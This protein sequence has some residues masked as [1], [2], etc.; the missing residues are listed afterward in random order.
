MKRV[1]FSRVRQLLRVIPSEA[2]DLTSYAKRCSRDPSLAL[3]MTTFFCWV[4]CL[5]FVVTFAGS[6]RATTDDELRAVRFD[7]N[8]DQRIPLDT[9][10]RDE[11]GRVVTLAD[12]FG[13]DKKPVVLVPGYFGCPMLCGAISNG[14]IESLQELRFDIGKDFTVLHLSIDPREGPAEAAAKKQTYLT[15]YGRHG[16]DAG[17][18]FLT[19]SEEATRRIADEIGFHYFYD[20]ATKQYAH[21]SGIVILTPEGKIARYFF[22]V[23]F[24]PKQLR[25]ALVEASQNKIGS[26]ID[27]LMLLCFHY[28]PL[29]GKYSFAILNVLRGCGAATVLAMAGFIAVSIK[30]NR[31][32]VNGAN[33]TATA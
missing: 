19:G 9:A 23:N 25:L 24:E 8:L 26:P 18:H 20:A 27:Q 33:G 30:R 28:N 4:V 1:K 16:A 17:W 3:R 14:L 7:Q 12:Y 5:L 6:A 2:K 29:T 10:F 13:K 31:A 21:P 15:R 22:G 11:N 32:R